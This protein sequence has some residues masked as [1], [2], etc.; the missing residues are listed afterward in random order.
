[1]YLPACLRIVLRSAVED[2]ELYLVN[3]DDES[4][5]LLGEFSGST[6]STFQRDLT[7]H[8]IPPGNVFIVGE[9]ND[10]IIFSERFNL[11]A[12]SVF[13][14]DASTCEGA[15]VPRDSCF[16]SCGGRAP[17]GC[18]C[19]ALCEEM[20]DCCSDFCVCGDCSQRSCQFRCGESDG[21]CSCAPDCQFSEFGCCDDFC[22]VCPFCGNIGGA[23]S[24]AG[25][26]ACGDGPFGSDDCYCDDA[27]LDFEDCC[28]DACF[29][30]GYCYV[31]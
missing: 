7:A 2:M 20:G 14:D 29:E 8:R 4:S 27:C 24:C 28:A 6:G 21:P 26:N 11:T 18:Y 31:A 30:C 25:P 9:S 22:D 12:N 3:Q 16:N 10:G 23:G 17:S 1:M 13:A 5:I 19:D 15:P